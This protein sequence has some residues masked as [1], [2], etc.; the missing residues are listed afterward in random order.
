MSY[1][2]SPRIERLLPLRIRLRR[3]GAHV[4]ALVDR[5]TASG[6]NFH[7]F[8]S[9]IR[10]RPRRWE[11]FLQALLHR[12]YLQMAGKEWQSNERLEFLGDSILNA[13]VAEHLFATHPDE[14]EGVL[15]KLRARLVNRKTLAMRARDMR[16]MDFLLL[17]PSAAQSIDSGSESILA[18]AFE[19]VLGAVYLDGGTDAARKFVFDMLLD[20]PEAMA[21][22]QTDDNYKSALLEHA[23]GNSLGIPRYSVI[24]EE[25]PE[26]DRRFTVEV[27]VGTVPLGTGTGRSKKD[28]E[29]AAASQALERIHQTPIPTRYSE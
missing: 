15:T 2:L 1:L 17:S 10:F 11:L 22:V 4:T 7:R 9:T 21:T 20:H 19:A 3:G 18:D 25:G 24:R 26:H 27:V 14:E 23:Q 6:F 28:A 5:L 12:S 8:E 13:I 29:Q 16:L